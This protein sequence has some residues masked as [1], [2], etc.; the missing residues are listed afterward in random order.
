MDSLD[1]PLCSSHESIVNALEDLR[2]RNRSGIVVQGKAGYSLLHA[3]DLLYARDKGLTTLADISGGEP[4][5]GLQKHHAKEFSL[6]VEFPA[7]TSTEYETFLRSINHRYTLL[8]ATGQSATIV[9]A[10]E[11]D[12]GALRLTGGYQCDGTPTHYFPRPRVSDGEVC[13]KWP[14]CSRPD[15]KKPTVHPAP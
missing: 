13:P 11:S 7:S 4:V 5:I 8:S 15:A 12:A 3:G 9:T 1:V 14:E 6:S 10:S 2:A